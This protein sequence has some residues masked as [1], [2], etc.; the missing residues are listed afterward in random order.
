MVI[1]ATAVPMRTCFQRGVRWVHGGAAEDIGAVM[2]HSLGDGAR[3]RRICGVSKGAG[4]VPSERGTPVPRPLFGDE[5]AWRLTIR[6]G[7][8]PRPHSPLWHHRPAL[9]RQASQS[10]LIRPPSSGE[11]A[12]RGRCWY[13]RQTRSGFRQNPAGIKCRALDMGRAGARPKCTYRTLRIQ[14][15]FVL[16]ALATGVEVRLRQ[17]SRDPDQI[18][19]RKS[20]LPHRRPPSSPPLNASYAASSPPPGRLHRPNI[21]QSRQHPGQPALVAR[22]PSGPPTPPNIPR[23]ESGSAAARSSEDSTNTGPSATCC[24][25]HADARADRLDQPFYT[26]ERYAERLQHYVRAHDFDLLAGMDAGALLA[27]PVDAA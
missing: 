13:T 27:G 24:A 10:R 5:P 20:R 15:A 6:S 8:A 23:R 21:G 7:Q 12:P 19:C 22:R 2:T 14:V 9:G 18:R 25:V 16:L 4:D 26:P 11:E 3:R 17:S 1:A